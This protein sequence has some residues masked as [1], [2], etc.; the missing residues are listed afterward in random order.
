MKGL[1]RVLAIALALALSLGAL[2][3]CNGGAVSSKLSA[4]VIRMDGGSQVR[5]VWDAVEGAVAY[6]ATVNGEEL[7]A[8]TAC[9]LSL[10]EDEAYTVSVR[11]LAADAAYHSDA[12]NTVEISYGF[13]GDAVVLRFAALSD[14][15][16]SLYGAVCRRCV[17]GQRRGAASRCLVLWQPRFSHL[18]LRVPDDLYKRNGG[19]VLRL[20]GRDPGL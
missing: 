16:V 14:V 12:S 17:P 10:T 1:K 5:V 11:A 2:V 8:Q 4:P 9:S 13:N 20:F 3:S 19:Y 6:V 18:H 7:P 15:H